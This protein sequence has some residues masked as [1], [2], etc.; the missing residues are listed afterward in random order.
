MYRRYIKRILDVTGAFVLLVALLPFWALI[1]LI[2]KL[3]SKGPVL[4]KQKRLGMN[5]VPFQI[6]KFRTMRTDAPSEMA[7][8]Q[9]YQS[10]RYITR[11]GVY[12]RT[13]SLDELPQLYNILKGDMSFVGFR[14]CLW[15]EFE[16]DEERRKTGAYAVRPGITGLAQIRG[17]DELDPQE[18]A[19]L[20]GVY[21]RNVGFDYDLR[22]LTKTL[23]AV[24]YKEGYHE[25]GA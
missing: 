1:A 22:I 11:V 5:E 7:T 8:N 2:I 4:F 9:L 18:K 20:D 25:G 15:N 13:L 12:L 24:F 21:A 14:P 10:G 17:R 6:Y 23:F 3:D 19:L 16:L